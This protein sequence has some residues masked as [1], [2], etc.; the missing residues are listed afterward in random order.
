MDSGPRPPLALRWQALRP[1]TPIQILISTCGSRG[2]E[3]TMQLA[4]IAM[5][6]WVYLWCYI[7]AWE[8]VVPAVLQS[9]RPPPILLCSK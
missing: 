8:L 4:T 7:L 5:I 9:P 6:D 1:R 2:N 3:Q